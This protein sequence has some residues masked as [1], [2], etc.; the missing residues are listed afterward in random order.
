MI[1][2]F[3]LLLKANI[4]LGVY[5]AVK[6][7]FIFIDVNNKNLPLKISD[8]YFIS[9]YRDRIIAY[10][11]SNKIEK[12]E[13]IKTA[14]C[15]LN[16][17]VIIYNKKINIGDYSTQ[18]LEHNLKQKEIFNRDLRFH[19]EIYRCKY[20]YNISLAYFITHEEPYA[21]AVVDFIINWKDY[22][23]VVNKKL[24][25]NGMEAAIKL[26]YLSLVDPLL[27]DSQAYNNEIRKELIYSIIIHA[28]YIYKNYDITF[29]GLE[30]N[31][32]LTCSVGLIYAS[33]LFPKYQSSKKWQNFG[34]RSLHRALENQ[35]SDDGVNFESSVQYHRFVFEMLVF[36]LAG[37]NKNGFGEKIN[38]SDKVSKIGIALLKLRHSNNYISRIGDSDGGKFLPCLNSLKNFNSLEYLDWFT[39]KNKK[40]YFETLIFN[41]IPQLRGLLNSNNDRNYQVGKYFSMKNRNLSLI[42]T[43][44]NI[45]TIGKGNHQHNDF[46]SFELY[47][48]SPFIVDPWSYCYTG[49]KY[50]RNK[51]RKT[52]SHNCVE[53]DNKEIIPVPSDNLFAMIGNIKVNI[54]KIEETTEYWYAN[55]THNGYKKLK[56]GSQI[57]TRKFQ[58]NKIKNEFE[59]ID[60]M[61]GKGNHFA[62]MHLFIPQKYWDLTKDGET[63]IFSNDNEV[64]KMSTTWSSLI[65][66]EG[67]VS[68]Y[69]LNK[70]PAYKIIL[71]QEYQDS[72]SVTLALDYNKR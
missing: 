38:I 61:N 57:H 53:I 13:L 56:N 48:I 58:F 66:D 35:F 11:E 26:I 15:F 45:G 33:L 30:S 40:A 44:N 46:L 65:I 25:Y 34:I 41:E 24:R 59:I 36:L 1:N 9:S 37:I 42:G 70:E 5:F 23:P 16:N 68:S 12:E 28:E 55:F 14:D 3:R 43:A 54:N 20:L 52:K 4:I 27:A 32:A 51:D 8:I 47:G 19:W 31:H 22:S 10:F 69:F 71:E 50:L 17:E 67:E 49:D 60:N 21:K 64:F 6:K 63:L 62:K 39:S 7:R 2:Y 29:Y 18:K 72:I